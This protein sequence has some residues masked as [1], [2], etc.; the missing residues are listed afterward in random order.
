[1]PR[2]ATDLS[3]IVVEASIWSTAGTMEK[4]GGGVP[5]YF[6]I[7]WGE[8]FRR[9]C[10]LMTSGMKVVEESLRSCL[11]GFSLLSWPLNLVHIAH[12]G[13][14]CAHSTLT[15]RS[16]LSTSRAGYFTKG[17]NCVFL[18]AVGVVGRPLAGECR[19]WTNS[20]D[21]VSWTPALEFD[22][23]ARCNLLAQGQ[24]MRKV[25]S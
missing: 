16:T 20:H 23:F 13:F 5:R 14:S 24:E 10:E 18:V 21:V 3:H 17:S 6:K 12:K 2:G 15:P 19:P 4:A 1:M 9:H 7:R 22:S 8:K 11:D 25:P